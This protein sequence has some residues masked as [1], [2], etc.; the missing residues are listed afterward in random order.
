MREGVEVDLSVVLQVVPMCPKEI[1][2]K[3][4]TELGYM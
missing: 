3:S 4:V 2:Y 1:I